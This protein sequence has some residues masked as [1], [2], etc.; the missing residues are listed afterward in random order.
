M[1]SLLYAF[2][3]E[4]SIRQTR[5][6]RVESLAAV[7]FFVG[8]LYGPRPFET[9]LLWTNLFVCQMDTNFLLYT[10]CDELILQ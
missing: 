10:F 2:F 4:D 9:A 7:Q 5:I 8:V 6:Y 3:P 1:V